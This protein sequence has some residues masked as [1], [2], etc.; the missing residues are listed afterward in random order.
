MARTI[1]ARARIRKRGLASWAADLIWPPRSLLSE[2][3]GRS[4]GGY[5]ACVVGRVEFPRCAGMRMLRVPTPE[6][7]GAAGVLLRSV[8]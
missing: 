1:Q 6:R 8:L 3:D 4:A 2:G 7:R 5:R